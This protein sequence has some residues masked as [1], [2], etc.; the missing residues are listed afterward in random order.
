MQTPGSVQVLALTLQPFGKENK[1]AMARLWGLREVHESVR[2]H[3]IPTPSPQEQ[4]ALLPAENASK[5]RRAPAE[6]VSTKQLQ[7]GWFKEVRKRTSGKAGG[8]L[9]TACTHRDGRQFPSRRLFEQAGG[10]G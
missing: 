2:R 7:N 1:A 6:A 10:L 3:A 4:L 9:Y 5:K 8:G